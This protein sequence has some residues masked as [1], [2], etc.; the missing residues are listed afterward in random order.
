MAVSIF[1][2]LHAA[3]PSHVTVPDDCPW[4]PRDKMR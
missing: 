1:L 2:S 3:R 4:V